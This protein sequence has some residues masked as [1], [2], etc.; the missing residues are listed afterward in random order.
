MQE[1]K[2]EKSEDGSTAIVCPVST[3]RHGR[4]FRQ[5]EDA[6]MVAASRRIAVCRPASRI[7]SLLTKVNQELPRVAPEP[8]HSCHDSLERGR[9]VAVGEKIDDAA[10]LQI[11]DDR[12][13][14]VPALPCPAID[15][16]HPWRGRGAWHI[17][18]HHM[19]QGVGAGMRSAQ[20]LTVNFRADAAG[21]RARQRHVCACVIA[22]SIAMYCHST[23]S[24]DGCQAGIDRDCRGVA[25][26]SGAE[27][28]PR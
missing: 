19:Q 14:A 8:C 12:P 11:A 24:R 15:A 7:L 25:G 18:A 16:D 21:Q 22:A 2:R 5:H 13:I 6:V 26:Q 20:A 28:D 23:R 27:R 4:C 3:L 9:G 10:P 1:K 17:A